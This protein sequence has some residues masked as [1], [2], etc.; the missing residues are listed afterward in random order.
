MSSTGPEILWRTEPTDD[1]TAAFVELLRYGDLSISMLCL[2]LRVV[3][4]LARDILAD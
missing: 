4:A 3:N 1:P 2:T